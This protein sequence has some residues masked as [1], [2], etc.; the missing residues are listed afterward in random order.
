MRFT[1][2]A[3]GVTASARPSELTVRLAGA[4]TTRDAVAFGLSRTDGTTVLRAP[5]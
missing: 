3:P 5:V 1:T 2:V 4:L